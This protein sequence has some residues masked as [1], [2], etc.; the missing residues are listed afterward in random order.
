MWGPNAPSPKAKPYLL[1]FLTNHPENPSDPPCP[2]PV[3][4]SWL[5]RGQPLACLLLTHQ[6]LPLP[7]SNLPKS[8]AFSWQ[9]SSWPSPPNVLPKVL[10][11]SISFVW[12]TCF[13]L[14]FSLFSFPLFLAYS[15]LP[16]MC[17]VALSL[18]AFLLLTF[19]TGVLALAGTSDTSI[20]VPTKENIQTDLES[21]KRGYFQEK[22]NK[23]GSTLL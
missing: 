1:L 16:P 8:T 11:A 21:K 12:Q 17:V 18:L 9:L 14:N 5:P 3:P 20:S 13:S 6:S 7:F 15:H 4:I 19:L 23:N 2:Q 22:K 10:Q